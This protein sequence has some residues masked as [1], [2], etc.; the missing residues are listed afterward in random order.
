[1]RRAGA[2]QG[3]RQPHDG[4]VRARLRQLSEEFAR[5]PE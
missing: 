2:G 5:R 4:K 3:H 1:M